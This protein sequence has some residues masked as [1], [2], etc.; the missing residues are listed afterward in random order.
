MMAMTSKWRN[1]TWQHRKKVSENRWRIAAAANGGGALNIARQRKRLAVM[2]QL[3]ALKMAYQRRLMAMAWH[4]RKYQAAGNN[5]GNITARRQR[6]RH[7]WR[8]GSS[9]RHLSISK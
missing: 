6:N 1:A 2:P 5:N 7:K 3:Y 8:S 4:Q 9:K